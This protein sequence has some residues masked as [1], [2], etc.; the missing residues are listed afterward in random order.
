[1]DKE[2]KTILL[3]N[4][5]ATGMNATDSPVAITSINIAIAL[6]MLVVFLVGTTV[7]G[8]LL[9]VLGMKIKRTVNTL[10]FIHLIFTYLVSASCMPFLA[11]D[12]LLG[13]HWVFGT[14]MCKLINSFGSV[15]MFTT[16]FL[17][18][19][20]SLDRYLL[21]CHPIW[22][23][24][25]RTIPRARRLLIGVWFASLALSSPYLAFREIRVMEK[26]RIECVNNYALSSDWEG[27]KIQALRHHIRLAL[28]VVRFLL[29]F[30]IPFFIIMGCYFWMGH[31]MKKKKLVRTGKPYRVLVASVASFFICW[32]P[33]HL[34]WAALLFGASH[35]IVKCLQVI[36][37]TVV[38]FNFC[39]TPILYLIVGEKFQQVFKTSILA[40]LKKGFADIIVVPEENSNISAQDNQMDYT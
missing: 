30:L 36:F 13:S 17:L 18:T 40:L 20:I 26:G 6:F 1:M 19:V 35:I 2:S 23:Q 28:F 39:F 14:V 16:V 10:W 8:L 5:S 38:C 4:A 34:F 15:G 37:V 9:W 25:N 12:V 21:I 7:N 27:E 31:N 32:L 33:Y 22:S 11:V 3:E 29:A 24:Q